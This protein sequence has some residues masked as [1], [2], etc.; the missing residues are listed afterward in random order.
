M[1]NF[2]R[3]PGLKKQLKKSGYPDI[4]LTK[5]DEIA[6]LNGCYFDSEKAW[7]VIDYIEYY[8]RMSKGEE[9]AGKRI[10][11]MD[12][13]TN[14]LLLPIFGWQ[15]PNGRRRIKKSITFIAKK[16]GKSSL[17]SALVP[18]LLDPVGDGEPGSEVY[19]AA[20]SRDQAGIVYRESASMVEASPELLKKFEIIRSTKTINLGTT[21]WARVL[22]AE[23]NT[24]EGINAHGLILDELHSWQDRK[25]FSAIVWAMAARTQPLT[26]VIS[27]AG[28]DLDSI[29]GDEYHYA[30]KIISGD[31]EDVTVWPLLF[32]ADENDDFDD[33]KTWKKANPSL[34]YAI[35]YERFEEDYNTAKQKGGKDWSDFKRYRFNIWGGAESPYLNLQKWE[36]DCLEE[37]TEDELTGIECYGGLDL[38]SKEDI[39]SLC[40][41]FKFPDHYKAIWRHWI[42]EEK[43]KEK[44]EKNEQNYSRWLESGHLFAI[45]GARIEQNL[46]M[47]QIARDFKKFNVQGFAVESYNAQGIIDELSGM[48]DEVVEVTAGYRH[49]NEPTKE[50]K[51]LID[52][53]KFKHNG[54]PVVNWM[55]SNLRVKEN[56]NNDIFPIKKD[57]TARYKIDGCIAAILGL[58]LAMTKEEFVS[59]YETTGSISLK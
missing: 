9:F 8:C 12:W 47:E 14:Q 19:L 58:K 38:S 37:F 6:L 48:I 56:S 51:S 53:G 26:F 34:G 59:I 40:F 7:K 10:E 28:A 18:Y 22:S 49:Y 1:A 52:A 55:M 11:L 41:V 24:A 43:I 46:V 39:T 21:C 23:A 33:P 57:K 32:E 25:F 13:Q 27:T 35:S 31:V 16:N 30:K 45:P 3:L 5:S 20:T 42:P 2:A 17:C 15:T 4:N 29:G 36:D 54:S 44:L 50:L